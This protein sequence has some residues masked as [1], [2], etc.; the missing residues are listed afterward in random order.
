MRLCVEEFLNEKENR[1]LNGIPNWLPFKAEEY[2]QSP[3]RA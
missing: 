3:M 2:F 1:G